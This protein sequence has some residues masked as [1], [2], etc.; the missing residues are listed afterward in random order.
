MIPCRCFPP[1][2]RVTIK[3]I[4][5]DDVGGYKKQL[6]SLFDAQQDYL[7]YNFDSNLMSHHQTYAL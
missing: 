3:Q 6:A 5:L 7:L 2:G 4:S 1:F